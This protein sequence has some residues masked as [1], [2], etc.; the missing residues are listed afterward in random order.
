MNPV[1]GHTILLA[2][3]P[4]PFPP[5]GVRITLECACGAVLHGGEFVVD[6]AAH[7]QTIRDEGRAAARHH[8]AAVV[9]NGES[10]E[11]GAK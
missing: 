11:P 6:A 3:Q 5:G 1:P 10:S 9:G 4:L 7:R 2:V 8:H